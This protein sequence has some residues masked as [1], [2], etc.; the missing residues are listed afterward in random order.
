MP[1]DK[2]DALSVFSFIVLEFAHRLN[3]I[4]KKEREAKWILSKEMV[5][6]PK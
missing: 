4:H 1:F 5:K 6:N 2:I 3:R